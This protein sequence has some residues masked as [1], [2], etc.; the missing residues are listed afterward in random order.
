MSISGGQF[1][2]AGAS[3]IL[4]KR[5]KAVHIHSRDDY[6][7]RLKWI[8]K[9]YTVLYDLQDRRAWLLDGASALLHL[10][11]AS[12]Q[13]D[14]DKNDPFK[15]LFLFEEHFLTE[16][17]A[18]FSGMAAAIHVLTNQA[19][20][21]LP[22]YAKPLEVRED[23]TTTEM[24][25]RSKVLSSTKRNYTLKDRIEGIYDVL[26]QMM[27]HQADVHSQDGIGF[28][29]KYTSRR[30]LE[31]FNFMDVATDE[32]PLWPCVATLKARGRG[33]IDLTRSLH[34]ITLF[35]TN[36]GELHRPVPSVGSCAGCL[37]DTEV[38]KG[39]DYLVVCTSELNE[40]LKKRGSQRTTPW[41]LVDEVYWLTPD[42]TFESC[43]C[44]KTSK[45][46][47][48]VQVLLPCS[49]PGF[50][51]RGFRSPSHL[52]S[53]GAVIFGHSWKFPLRWNKNGLPEEGEPDDED[54][55]EMEASFK[56]GGIG[57]S[58]GSKSSPDDGATAGNSSS[59]S[60]Q[61]ESEQRSSWLQIMCS[62]RELA[63]DSLERPLK[64]SSQHGWEVAATGAEEG[65]KPESYGPPSKRCK[66][67]GHNG[68]SL[69]QGGLSDPPVLQLCEPASVASPQ[70]GVTLLQD[71]RKTSHCLPDSGQTALQSRSPDTS[72]LD[73]W[74]SAFRKLKGKEKET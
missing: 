33:W 23:E 48:R 67:S 14:G 47:D 39:Q 3:I 38:P 22:L 54:M 41:R 56:N 73:P 30:Q 11:R 27:A 53:R 2:T 58:L 71:S 15:D 8:A 28:R 70:P 5:D 43:Q 17:S 52:P 37:L 62:P 13:H 55:D 1:V 25:T 7:T 36:F 26:E 69:Q 4:G 21:E 29:V 51:G 68:D 64:R 10:V 49:M 60:S 24:G 12:L 63:E 40:I 72:L 57:T 20:T 65:E 74:R 35:G 42:K 6:V 61:V 32:S 50:W 45:K 9:K 34:A 31:G 18:P 44:K 19:N 66:T 59:S 16:S 46:H